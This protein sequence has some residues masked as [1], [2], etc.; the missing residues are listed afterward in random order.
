[1][2]RIYLDLTARATTKD[3]TGSRISIRNPS[4]R[5][6]QPVQ[7]LRI[8]LRGVWTP[9]S[10]SRFHPVGKSGSPF[11]G[12]H[13]EASAELRDKRC[14]RCIQVHSR[15][16]QKG[17]P[18]LFHQPLTME[19]IRVTGLSSFHASLHRFRGRIFYDDLLFYRTCLAIKF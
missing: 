3:A 18:P 16:M 1:M 10:K 17:T 6:R 13:P 15:V 11:L 8:F 2:A 12:S 4:R 19:C 5:S 7:N 9:V 14:N